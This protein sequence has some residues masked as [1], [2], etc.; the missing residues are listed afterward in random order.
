VRKEG[1]ITI[2][3]NTI[4]G[5]FGILKRGISGVYQHVSRQHLGKYLSEF[6]FR[7]NGRKISDGERTIRAIQGFEGKRLMYKDSR[8]SVS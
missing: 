7:Y 1:M 8:P 6:E 2:T 4:E 3:T 5:F